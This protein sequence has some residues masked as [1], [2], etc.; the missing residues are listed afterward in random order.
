MRYSFKTWPQQAEWSTLREIWIEADRAGFWD[1][2]W[3][4]DHFYPPKSPPEEPIM[5]SWTLLA[6][7]AGQTERLRFGTMVSA[8]TFRHPVVLAKMATTVDHISN[9]RLE[10]GI[11]T[12]WHEE[13]HHAYDIA[14]P[15]LG[16]RFDRLEETLTILDGLMTNDVFSF[17]GKYHHLQQ[18][19]FEPKPIQ[20][21]RPP[22]VIGGAGMR[23]TLPL[24][25][26]WADQWNYPDFTGDMDAFGARVRRLRELCESSGRDPEEIEISVQFRYGNDLSEVGDRV[27]RYRENGASHI[28]VSFTPPADPALPILVGDYLAGHIQSDR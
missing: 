9:G 17:E 22:F 8:N 11:G 3:L 21:P 1:A 18:A 7:L 24:A 26:K 14:L 12:G 19:R 25:A 6:A 20:S 4:N 28:V 13:E 15:S 2:V 23:R 16:E 5:E 10:I 27:A